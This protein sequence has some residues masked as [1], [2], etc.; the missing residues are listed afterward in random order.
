VIVRWTSPESTKREPNQRGKPTGVHI[1][2]RWLARNYR[3]S[4][5]YG[6]YEIL[7]PRR[8]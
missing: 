4:A 5:R 7:V 1:L 2:D 6:F 8:G 3:A